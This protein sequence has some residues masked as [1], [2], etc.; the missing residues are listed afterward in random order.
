MMELFYP[1]SINELLT[2]AVFFKIIQSL[3]VLIVLWFISKI[4]NNMINRSVKQKRKSYS[5]KKLNAYITTTIT[6]VL[7][8]MIWFSMVKSLA[9]MISIISVGIALALQEVILAIAG[10]F[11]IIF[12]K[13][14]EVGDRIEIN[15]NKGDIIDIDVYNTTILEIE[16]WV[17]SDQATGRIAKI[18]NSEVFRYP[19]FN[20]NKGW[21]FIWD[22]VSVNITFESDYKAAEKILLSII[23]E[24]SASIQDDVEKSVRKLNR[25]YL[26]HFSIFT[27]KVYVTIQDSGIEVTLRFLVVVKARRDLEEM[28]FRQFL[29]KIKGKKN[30]T[31][32]YN[33]YRITG[34]RDH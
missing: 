17:K 16:N 11:F 29:D 10:W 24:Y 6:I 30:V 20:Y 9:I 2:N 3:L 27:P 26:V 23:E 4:V 22:E 1:E 5:M 28:V 12:K 19:I 31:L 7:I 32:A 18:P 25:K 34:E 14:Y 15:G 13:P 8:L 21:K 33:T